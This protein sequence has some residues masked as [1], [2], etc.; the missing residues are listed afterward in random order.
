[1]DLYLFNL[2]NQLASQWYWFDI[3]GV[4]CAQYLGYILVVSFLFLF[5]VRL[6]EY[7][8]TGLK[9]LAAVVLSRFVITEFI[10]WIWPRFRPFV[11]NNVNLL[12]EHS[13][14]A[15][16]P[17]GHAAFYFALASIIYMRN[18]NLGSLFLLGAFLISLSRVFVGIHWPSDVLAGAI[19]G[20]FSAWLIHKFSHKTI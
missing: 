4:F 13:A 15:S 6:G 9:A 19:I 8:E 18:R 17:S 11:E 16:F 2:I 12:V 3:L 20:I 1:M 5:I 7:W 14:S 10:Y